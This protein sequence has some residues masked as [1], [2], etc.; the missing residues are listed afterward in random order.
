MPSRMLQEA[1]AVLR[2]GLNAALIVG[3]A[4]GGLLVGTLGS[5]WGLA[6]DAA[7]Y[8]VAAAALPGCGTE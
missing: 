2:L 7:A 5:G 1:N 3:A 6:I 4:C 8:V